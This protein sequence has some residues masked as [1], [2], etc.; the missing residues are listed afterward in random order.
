MSPQHFSPL[1]RLDRAGFF[2]SHLN[3]ILYLDI[4]KPHMQIGYKAVLPYEMRLNG[5]ESGPE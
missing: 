3:P 4:R 2:I 1:I 5:R